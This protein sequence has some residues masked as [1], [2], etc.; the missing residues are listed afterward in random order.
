MTSGYFSMVAGR[1]RIKRV[2]MLQKFEMSEQE[3]RIPMRQF[4]L[5]RL[6]REET[7]KLS[8]ELFTY[9]HE[10]KYLYLIKSSSEF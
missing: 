8:Y 1:R 2:L 9:K 4:K 5:V 10:I 6:I 3:V 7:K